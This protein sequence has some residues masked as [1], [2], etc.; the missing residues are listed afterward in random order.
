MDQQPIIQP[1]EADY[2]NQLKSRFANWRLSLIGAVSLIIVAAC[3]IV[4]VGFLMYWNNTDRKYDIARPG[5]RLENQ[6]LSV[7]SDDIDRTS[8]VTAPVAKQK[9]DYLNKEIKTLNGFADFKASDLSDQDIQLAPS[10][11]PSY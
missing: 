10:D 1:K 7:E 8:P 4:A 9:I 3:G 11:R 5:D 2:N 6:T